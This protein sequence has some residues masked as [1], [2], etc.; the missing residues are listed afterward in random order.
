MTDTEKPVKCP[1]CGWGKPLLQE[2]Y[3]GCFYY[4]K[5]NA[6]CG[7]RSKL[8]DSTELAVQAWN[9]LCSEIETGQ[10]VH[11]KAKELVAKELVG[12]WQVDPDAIVSLCETGQN[13]CVKCRFSL[14]PSKPPRWQD[15]MLAVATRKSGHNE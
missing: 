14:V 4:C 10:A 8:C 3:G 7:L 5:T 1:M 11:E 6:S 2:S 15:V 9:L 12:E 13:L